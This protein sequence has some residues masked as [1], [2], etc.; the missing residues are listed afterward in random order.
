MQEPVHLPSSRGDQ[1][2]VVLDPDDGMLFIPLAPAGYEPSPSG[3]A[4][5]PAYGVPTDAELVARLDASDDWLA[6]F[7]QFTHLRG[8]LAEVSREF[9]R[10]GLTVLELP[11]N[12]ERTVALRK[13]L[14]AKD[15]AVRCRLA[16]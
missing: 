3:E 11:R 13:L 9:A 7:F 16:S 2:P 12:P 14:E 8:D 4:F 15:C 5:V 10:L 1:I 6:Q